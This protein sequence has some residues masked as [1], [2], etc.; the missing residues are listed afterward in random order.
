MV[1]SKWFPYAIHVLIVL[2][3][4]DTF[5]PL[6]RYPLIGQLWVGEGEMWSVPVNSVTAISLLTESIWEAS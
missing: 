6:K 5:F 2:L 4:G 3:T 1:A